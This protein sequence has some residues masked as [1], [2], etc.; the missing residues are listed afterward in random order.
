MNDDQA[1]ITRLSAILEDVYKKYRDNGVMPDDRK[2]YFSGYADALMTLKLLSQPELEALIEDANMKVFG[3]SVKDRR[4]V[5]DIK[6][7][8][9]MFDS[10]ACCAFRGHPA[11]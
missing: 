6:A 4:E 11:T 9:S 1:A 5:L 2:Q 8:P 7:D 10:P 3:M